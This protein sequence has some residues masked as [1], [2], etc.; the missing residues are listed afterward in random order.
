MKREKLALRVDREVIEGARA[1]AGLSADTPVSAVIRYA[2][3]RLAGTDTGPQLDCVG[4]RGAYFHRL[5]RG[6][7]A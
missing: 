6:K 7:T 2:L 3:A 5:S 4:G 1:A